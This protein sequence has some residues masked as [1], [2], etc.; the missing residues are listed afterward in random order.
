MKQKATY[1]Y[2]DQIWRINCRVFLF[3]FFY[4]LVNNKELLAY[5]SI[6][7][8][9]ENIIIVGHSL[10]SHMI[11]FFLLTFFYNVTIYYRG[12]AYF[13][14]YFLGSQFFLIFY[15]KSFKLYLDSISDTVM[16]IEVPSDLLCRLFLFFYPLGY[17][18][19]YIVDKRSR[20]RFLW[21]H[22]VII[23]MFFFVPTFKNTFWL[24]CAYLVF[25]IKQIFTFFMQQMNQ[26]GIEP[27][28]LPLS[29]V[30]STSWAT[31]SFK[32]KKGLEP[33]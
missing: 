30:R 8:R 23:V 32:V 18:I 1:D 22:I 9:H 28:T 11:G 17:V 12:F 14:T 5:W 13:I 29:G 4:I 25:E 20:N 33:L 7:C 2:N 24:A 3:N 10:Y 26:N 21:F 31:G 19:E 6:L 16:F 15:F 27:P